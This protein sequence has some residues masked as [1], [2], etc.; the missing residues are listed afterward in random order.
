MEAAV[1]SFA[2]EKK[3]MEEV[4]ASKI[5]V[6]TETKKVIMI[7][8]RVNHIASLQEIAECKIVTMTDMTVVPVLVMMTGIQIMTAIAVMAAAPERIGRKMRIMEEVLTAG[9]PV[10]KMITACAMTKD[11]LKAVSVSEMMTIRMIIARKDTAAIVITNARVHQVVQQQ[12]VGKINTFQIN[13]L[14]N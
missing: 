7:K 6:A 9:D 14:V 3:N 10:S 13:T 11:V 12:D 2:E 4:M 8:T 1:V 5:L